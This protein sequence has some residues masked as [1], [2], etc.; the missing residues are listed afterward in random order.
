M[1][2][3]SRKLPK[4][5]KFHVDD[6]F[7][8]HVNPLV[9]TDFLQNLEKIFGKT[10]PL[11]I[12]RGRTQEYLGMSIIFTSPGCVKIT[13]YDFIKKLLKKPP[14]EMRGK[15]ATAAPEY[16]IKTRDD[17]PILLDDE[18]N[19]TFHTITATLLYLIQRVRPDIQLSTAFL[20]TKE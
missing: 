3:G 9:V 12:R 15:K 2:Q 1:E 16:L 5:V 6:G 10:D 20:C 13:M 17:N 4:T 8:S 14:Q 11:T 18:H 19:G 7:V